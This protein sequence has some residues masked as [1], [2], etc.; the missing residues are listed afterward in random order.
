M[1]EESSSKIALSAV[2]GQKIHGLL[3]KELHFVKSTAEKMILQT[4][5]ERSLLGDG[6]TQT[7]PN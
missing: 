1:Q 4:S 3:W 6:L 7:Q 5:S 2:L